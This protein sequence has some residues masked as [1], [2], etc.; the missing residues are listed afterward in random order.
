MSQIFINLI[1]T[2]DTNARIPIISDKISNIRSSMGLLR[3]RVSDEVLCERNLRDRMEKI[4]V[5][6]ENIKDMSDDLYIAVQGSIA[7][8]RDT[9]QRI[10]LGNASKFE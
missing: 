10:N 9:E 1:E 8:H 4:C 3:W 5:D 6:L 7:R 2:E